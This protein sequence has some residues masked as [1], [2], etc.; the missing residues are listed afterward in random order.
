MSDRVLVGR[1]RE[2]KF[3]GPLFREEPGW[4]TI[5]TSKLCRN[6]ESPVRLLPAQL[7]PD[8]GCIHFQE[9]V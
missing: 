2:C 7:P 3:Y 8:F 9:P 4:T 6:P 5:S 1:C